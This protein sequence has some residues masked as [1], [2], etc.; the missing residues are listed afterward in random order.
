MGHA[1]A[2]DTDSEQPQVSRRTKRIP[3]RA[4]LKARV[5]IAEAQVDAARSQ[6]DALRE[7]QTDAERIRAEV[8]AMARAVLEETR[9]EAAWILAKARQFIEA[10]VHTATAEAAL[11]TERLHALANATKEQ[12]SPEAGAACDASALDQDDGRPWRRDQT[13]VIAHGSDAPPSAKLT[14]VLASI[15]TERRAALRSAAPVAHR[16]VESAADVE[17]TR[18]AASIAELESVLFGTA[19]PKDATADPIWP[20]ALA[21]SRFLPS[22]FACRDTSVENMVGDAELDDDDFWER[23][24]VR[25]P[26]RRRHRH[27]LLFGFLG[28]A[29]L[30]GL[31]TAGAALGGRI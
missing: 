13:N 3:T 27:R 9:A 26:V 14:D 8:Q 20:T 19:I 11:A 6:I 24:R 29:T 7:A 5:L 16:T 1:R 28:V 30:V 25:E 15:D 4:Q 12:P 2:H 18:K 22:R 21:E 31:S 10:E 17:V 23:A